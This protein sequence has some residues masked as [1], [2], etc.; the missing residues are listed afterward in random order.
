M[1]SVFICEDHPK[2]REHI[3]KAV[4]EYITTIDYDIKLALA[5][6]GP[7]SVLDYLSGNPDTTGLYILDVELKHEMNGIDLASVIKE[8][9]RNS[10]I[11]FVTTHSELAYLTFSQKVDAMD[12]IIKD[13][14]KDVE[15]RV[16]ECIDKAYNEYLYDKVSSRRYYS[17]KSGGEHWKIPVDEILY[18]E[19]HPSVR[20]RVILHMKDSQIEHRCLISEIADREPEFIRCN[21]SYVVNTMHVL[22]VDKA[23]MEA[24]MTDG[25]KVPLTASRIKDLMEATSRVLR[26]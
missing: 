17:L 7:T 10:K 15:E 19:T 5:A 16:I 18:F 6:D 11:V 2:H 26:R 12:Y 23:N 25:A 3:K 9:D 1:L 14:P 4:K 20:H 22:C 8:K 21:K 13:S 24:V